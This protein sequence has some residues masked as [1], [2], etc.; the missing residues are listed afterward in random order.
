MIGYGRR[1]DRIEDKL[2]EATREYS[3]DQ[4]VAGYATAM[5]GYGVAVGALVLLAALTGRRAPRRLSA[6]DVALLT[7]A[8]HKLSRLV[9]KDAVTSPLR[10]AGTRFVGAAGASE[11]HEEV[12]GRGLRH[13][14][15]ELVSCPFCLDMWAATALT[16]GLVLAPRPTR[17]VMGCLTAVAG[18][19][20]LQLAYDMAKK[21]SGN[22]G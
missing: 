17:L 5:A 6:G 7:A 12:R 15:G 11:L 14:F 3:D 21:A 1:M 19:D 18:A 10:A 22:T 4:P 9:A 16:A 2:A 8:T 13:A 20:F